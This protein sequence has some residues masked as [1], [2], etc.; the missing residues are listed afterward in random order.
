MV[1]LDKDRGGIEELQNTNDA[2]PTRKIRSR[3][4]IEEEG[5]YAQARR[6]S[7]GLAEDS[8]SDIPTPTMALLALFL[9]LS[10]IK[11]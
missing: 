8:A 2:A 9:I 5:Q 11:D 3:V 4:S 6:E 1:S 7:F 10:H